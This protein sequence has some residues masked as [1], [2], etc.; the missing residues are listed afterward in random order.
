MS[1]IKHQ[2]NKER[3]LRQE[4]RRQFSEKA[5]LELRGSFKPQNNT[6]P[7]L[8]GAISVLNHLG[9]PIPQRVPGKSDHRRA[10]ETL[11]RGLGPYSI[12]MF[13]YEALLVNVTYAPLAHRLAQG[14]SVYK[15]LVALKPELKFTRKQA[16]LLSKAPAKATPTQAFWWCKARS[17]GLHANKAWELSEALTQAHFRVESQTEFWESVLIWFVNHE[18]PVAD[19][20]PFIDFFADTLR[21]DPNWSI[22]GRTVISITRLVTE[23]H[24]TLSKKAGGPLVEW[25]SSGLAG[26]STSREE[27]DDTIFYEIKELTNSKDLATEGKVM[28][29]CVYSYLPLVQKGQCFIFHLRKGSNLSGEMLNPKIVAT[30]RLN[31]NGDLVE[32][33]GKHNA[34]LSS[35]HRH[36]IKQW[37]QAVG[38]STSKFYI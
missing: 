25:E 15:A 31:Q 29:H 7:Y 21:R 4:E 24:A 5:A 36:I 20:G 27:Y 1:S 19:A 32:A 17:L 14:V 35:E 13:L 8:Q 37:A 16:H 9:L 6:P 34:L 30:I 22:K 10:V 18:V 23:W 3:R 38:I 2:I 33:R 26:F 28:G 11:R 12:P